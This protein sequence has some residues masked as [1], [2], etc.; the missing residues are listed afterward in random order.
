MPSGFTPV[1]IDLRPSVKVMIP[2]DKP[3]GATR[4]SPATACLKAQMDPVEDLDSIVELGLA[5]LNRM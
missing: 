3:R 2:R 5:D 4:I 1:V